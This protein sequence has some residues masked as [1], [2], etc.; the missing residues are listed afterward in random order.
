MVQIIPS[1][2]AKTEQEYKDKLSQ[3]EQSKF[4]EGGWVQI[5]FMDN[6]FV[7]NLSIGTEIVAK[8]PTKQKIEAQLMVEDPYFWATKFKGIEI[9]RFIAPIES[10]KE[11][12]DQFVSFVK[13]NTEA[14]VGFSFNPSTDIN[15]LE[16]YKEV[17][18]AVLIMSV[19]PGF[20]GQ[21][22]MPEALDKVKKAARLR[23]ENNLHFLIGV[24][25][26]VNSL[27]AKG[28]ADGGANYLVIGSHLL[29]GDIDENLEKIWESIQG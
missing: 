27:V 20:G 23:L 9:T 28:L 17:A 3:I 14:E 12:L 6:K 11:L 13:A 5:D 16:D 22:F 4:F 15:R 19:N 25:G 21:E 26:G 2:L 29:Q 24:D 7:P 1:I 10:D 8:Y 18:Q